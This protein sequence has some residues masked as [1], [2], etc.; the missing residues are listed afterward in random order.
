MAISGAKQP[1]HES[2]GAV[3][4]TLRLRHLGMAFFWASSML[5]FRSSILLSGNAGT[6]A[7][8]TMVTVVSFTV[9]MTVLFLLAARAERTPDFFAH[10]PQQ[11]FIVA[12]LVGFALL[13]M[14]GAFQGTALFGAIGLGAALTGA[15]YG[16]LWGSWAECFGRMHPT[17]TALY[18]PLSFFLSAVLFLAILFT[19]HVAA[20]PPVAMM[21][22][23]PIISFGCLM[24]CRRETSTPVTSPA[25]GR[26]A[27]NMEALSTLISLL[28]ASAILSCLFGFMWELTVMSVNS[29]ND[30]HRVPLFGNVI[31]AVVMVAFVTIAHKW[32]DLGSTLRVLVPLLV[33]LFAVLPFFW[34]ER[35]V[36]LNAVMSTCYGVFDVII[37]YSVASAAYDFGVSGYVTGGIVRATSILCRLIGIGTGYLVML[38]PEDTS[39]PLIAISA[40]A[41]YALAMLMVFLFSSERSRTAQAKEEA[42]ALL[43]GDHDGGRG[44][45]PDVNSSGECELGST[46]GTATGAYVAAAGQVPEGVPDEAPAGKAPNGGHVCPHPCERSLRGID[47]ALSGVLGEAAKAAYSPL[48]GTPEMG[49]QAPAET[50]DADGHLS[51]EN[52][53]ATSP[54]VSDPSASLAAPSF[55][56]SAAS[57]DGYDAETL[58][59]IAEDYH[60]T[61]REAEVLPYLARGRSARIIA[62]ALFVSE[63]TIRTHTRRILEKTDLHSKQQLIDLIDRYL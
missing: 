24:R 15:G 9:N 34:Q 33:V 36:L 60:L 5:T 62:D 43:R 27:R 30:A 11:T 47:A 18:A 44:G 4:K 55:E 42:A 51:A 17:R 41:L 2:I 53:V 48:T 61:R 35:P 57:G 39:I 38:I 10:I 50:L 56:P 63:S 14:A 37:W 6:P 1:E 20:I 7:I 26:S 22:P 3:W 46:D 40:T 12:I 28:V 29:V 58:A 16:Y 52:C 25:R 59:A 21:I 8:A 31:A 13:T 32:V 23:L 54:A 45:G 19:A 49:R